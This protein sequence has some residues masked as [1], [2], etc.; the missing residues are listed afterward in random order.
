M[1]DVDTSKFQNITLLKSSPW[2]RA[3]DVIQV[4]G[5]VAQRLINDK[6]AEP[7]QEPPKPTQTRRKVSKAE[8]KS[9][10]A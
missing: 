10:D 7:A 4:S 1:V 2:G 8:A 6:F 9:G 5:R 3:G